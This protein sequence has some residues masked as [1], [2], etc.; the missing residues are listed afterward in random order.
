MEELVEAEE[1]VEEVVD[2]PYLAI[3]GEDEVRL[4]MQLIPIDDAN[5]SSP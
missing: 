4:E 1:M 2:H 5:T 3:L